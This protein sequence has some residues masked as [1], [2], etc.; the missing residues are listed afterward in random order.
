VNVY[1]LRALN[2]ALPPGP[3]RF[4]TAHPCQSAPN[5]AR[6]TAGGWAEETWLNGQQLVDR[7]QEKNCRCPEVCVSPHDWTSTP[8]LTMRTPDVHCSKTPFARSSPFAFLAETQKVTAGLCFF[9]SQPHWTSFDYCTLAART[10]QTL[11][12]IYRSDS[13][14]FTPMPHS[15]SETWRK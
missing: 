11:P 6:H 9:V 4:E 10:T 15:A 13:T 2:Q 1:Q 12:N 8:I 3:Q 5:S 7:L 14:R